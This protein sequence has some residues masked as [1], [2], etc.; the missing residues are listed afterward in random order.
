MK[1]AS[2]YPEEDTEFAP[3]SLNSFL[4]PYSPCGAETRVNFPG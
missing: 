1:N 4:C 3:L 2:F